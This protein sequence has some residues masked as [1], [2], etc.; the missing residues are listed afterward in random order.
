ML[1]FKRYLLFIIIFLILLFGFFY[2]NNRDTEIKEEKE[3][4][5]VSVIFPHPDD[6]YWIY[7]REGID[8]KLDEA[9]AEG[10]DIKFFYPNSNYKIDDITK[11][12]K[13]QIAAKTD[14]IVLQGIDNEEYRKELLKAYNKGIRII[15]V[16]TDLQDFPEHLF[17]GTDNY[18][19]GRTIAEGMIRECNGRAR[20]LLV[21]AEENYP[22]LEQRIRGIKDVIE[23]YDSVSLEKICYDNYEAMDFMK[24]YY[25]EKNA[26]TLVCIEGTG[27]LT[28][29]RM[30]KSRDSRFEHIFGFDIADVVT[31]GVADGV[32]I[33]DTYGM[34]E[35]IVDELI[36][37]SKNGN[38]S[39]NIIHT[40]IK[41]ISSENIDNTSGDSE[42][43]Q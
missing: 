6:G 10:I 21:S 42:G 26:D 12:L 9:A 4:T 30:F 3:I 2:L 1:K 20:V 31:N 25:G 11:I 15:F 23:K 22:N 36:N 37:Y 33:Q 29:S 8:E 5:R 38:Y 18:E 28:L 40:S 41:Y 24:I 43:K 16:D 35:K 14:V 13:Q 7:V 17:I 27:A 39:E 19:A 34:G 32:V